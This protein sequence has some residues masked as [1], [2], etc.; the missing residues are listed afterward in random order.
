[1]WGYFY[2]FVIIMGIGICPMAHANATFDDAVRDTI[3]ACGDIGR[4]FDDMKTLAGINTAVTGVGTAT[5]IGAV[6]V[7]LSKVGL[8]EQ[9]RA[10][11][12]QICD[13]GGCD[14]TS[15]D[16][17][18]DS[19]FFN[20]ILIPM[21]Q[22]DELKRLNIKSKKLGNWRTG[23][24][25]GNTATHVAGAIIAGKNHMEKSTRQKIDTCVAAVRDLRRAVIQAR[26]DHVD[27][28]HINYA[29]NI[30]NECGPWEF[31]DIEK[32]D[33]R[34][35]GAM[36]SSITGGT[37]GA[38]GVATS[39]A[40]NSPETRN[41]NSETGNKH[42]KNLNTASNI[43]GIGA[44]AASATATVFNASQISIIRRAVNIAQQCQGAIN[45]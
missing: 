44:T 43:L 16:A 11:E 27:H 45:D 28:D 32:I 23:L 38:A 6:A 17:M 13:A 10:L 9:I 15:V 12:Q 3:V 19:D 42:E 14:P 18:S 2:I 33:R 36:W 25:A 4:E 37:V 34:A 31:I 41:N 26:L 39:I 40:A 8:D 29:V 7:G 24:L 30:I 1:M 35:N 21:G 20:Y 5:G 22:I